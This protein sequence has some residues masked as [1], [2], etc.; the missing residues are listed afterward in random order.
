MNNGSLPVK[1]NRFYPLLTLSAIF[2]LTSLVLLSVLGYNFYRQSKSRQA[3]KGPA[4]AALS[5]AVEKKRDSLQQIYSATVS[6]FQPDTLQR[7][8]PAAD[9]AGAQ[10]MNQ[11]LNDYYR[12]KNEI[13]TLLNDSSSLA[14][15][16]LA[17]QKIRQLQLRVEQLS[18]R[19]S[20][21]EK[22]NRRLR[23]LLDQLT[24]GR[25]SEQ[26]LPAPVK[27]LV[28]P[29]APA[30]PANT[31]AVFTAT[32]LRLTAADENNEEAFSADAV[33]RF[34]GTL[35]VRNSLNQG[36]S[37]LMLVLIQP[38]GR[39]LRSAWESGS[40]DTE[41]GRRIYSRKI[42]FEYTR[43]EPR[44]L[45]FSLPLDSCQ[46]GTYTLQVYSRG[47]LIGKASRQVS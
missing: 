22:E 43:G 8:L 27:P 35:T 31:D 47:R 37:E 39:V 34:L 14:G 7:N 32:E 13:S 38:D 2:L 29:A 40:F 19:N 15:L 16:E 17:T 1:E 23:T 24:G 5:P 18:I 26:N 12:L 6:N 11:R 4:S 36:S 46:K 30:L 21:I 9:T 42:R 20:D 3:G 41:S 10:E 45:D 44:Q 25:I 33:D 28:V